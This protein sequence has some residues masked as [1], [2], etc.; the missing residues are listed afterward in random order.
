MEEVALEMGFE[1]TGAFALME[2]TG[3]G[4][5][6]QAASRKR[7][8]VAVVLEDLMW[9]WKTESAL[10]RGCGGQGSGHGSL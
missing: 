1:D 6:N 4:G 7:T 8:A 3:E 10:Q 5:V 9:P 2:E